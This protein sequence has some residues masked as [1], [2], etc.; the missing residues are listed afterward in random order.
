MSR[1]I[2]S[3][4]IM[5]LATRWRSNYSLLLSADLLSELFT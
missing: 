1:E 5:Q 3:K 2:D 4:N